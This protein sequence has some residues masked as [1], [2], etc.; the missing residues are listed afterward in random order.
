ML[1]AD[2]S[3]VGSVKSQAT[4]TVTG[5]ERSLLHGGIAKHPARELSL[6]VQR[7]NNLHEA[8]Q[9]IAALERNVGQLTTQPESRCRRRSDLQQ[10]PADDHSA[11]KPTPRRV[12]PHLIGGRKVVEVLCPLV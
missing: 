11:A 1:E 6:D 12:D 2:V 9:L 7:D 10:V 4:V 3:G 8:P 5:V